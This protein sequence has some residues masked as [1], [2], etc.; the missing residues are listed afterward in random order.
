FKGEMLVAFGKYTGSGD[1][2][3]K[4]TGNL[5]G[6]KREFISDVKFTDTDTSRQFIPRL[7][8]TRRV[9]WLLDEIRLHGESSALKDEV[10]RL[11]RQ[12]GIVTPYTAYLIME[13][14]TRRNVP[15]SMQSMPQMQKDERAKGMAGSY[16]NSVGAEA[17]DDVRR[18]GEQANVNATRLGSLKYSD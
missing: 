13:D 1:G 2:A 7:W 5:N 4:I 3:V 10:V 18:S 12:W 15:L 16:F 8:A 17:K 11:S 14:E 6:E 9:G